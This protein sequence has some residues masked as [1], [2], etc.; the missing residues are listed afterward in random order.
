LLDE[1][2]KTCFFEK[3]QQKT[4]AQ[5]GIFHRRCQKLI[6]R[7]C[8]EPRLGGRGRFRDEAINL[9][10]PLQRKMDCHGRFAA[11]Q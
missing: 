5:W 7:H 8:E 1:Q 11:S 10:S 4:F 3:K 6:P 2:S 9:S